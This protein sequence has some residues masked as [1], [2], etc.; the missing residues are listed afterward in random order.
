MESMDNIAEIHEKMSMISETVAGHKNRLIDNGF[1]EHLA[2][3]MGSQLHYMLTEQII[4]AARQKT[5][6]VMAT[7]GIV[8]KITDRTTGKTG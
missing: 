5:A 7:M 2:C 6:Q 1:P 4:E 3:E 8:Q